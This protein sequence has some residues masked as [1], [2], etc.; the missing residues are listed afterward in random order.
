MDEKGLIKERL[1]MGEVLRFYGAAADEKNRIPCFLHHGKDRN[2]QIYGHSCYCFVCGRS[3]D[4][5]GFVME[6]FGLDF[7]KALQKL[8]SDFGLGIMGG[9]KQASKAEISNSIQKAKAQ[10]AINSLSEKTAIREY[11]E[12]CSLLQKYRQDKEKYRPKT[13]AEFEMPNPI[14]LKAVM[15]Y[16][17]TEYWLSTH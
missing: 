8:D 2:M 6:W 3:A 16:E 11:N 12:K 5:F 15:E 9:T 17:K 10:K 14:W 7:Q 13:M 4:I 1:T